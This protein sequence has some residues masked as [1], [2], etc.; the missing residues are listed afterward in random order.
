MDPNAPIDEKSNFDRG[1]G[2]SAG[3]PDG[4]PYGMMVFQQGQLVFSNPKIAEML[5][6]TPEELHSISLPT[7]CSNIH[8]D[9]C[10][11][12]LDL[13]KSVQSGDHIPIQPNIRL[14]FADGSIRQVNVLVNLTLH[15]GEHAV[16]I[17]WMD[18]TPQVGY[19][20]TLQDQL[21]EVMSDVMTALAMAADM[22]QTLEIILVN[23]RNVLQYDRAGLF[24]LD[25]D[26]HFVLAGKTNPEEMSAIPSHGFS[27][28]IVLQL[29]RTKQPL[30]IEDIQADE[31]FAAWP[32]MLP[33]STAFAKRGVRKIKPIT[34]M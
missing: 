2:S 18:I 16:Q 8:P 24:L 1:E 5:G 4:S 33:L 28:P 31:R 19:E 20:G 32:D 22:N 9:D 6:W 10:S 11:F 26:E 29:Q 13:V 15:Q 34:K 27:D 23:L 12:F 7:I 21:N 17:H 25:K 30:V 3:S 14:R